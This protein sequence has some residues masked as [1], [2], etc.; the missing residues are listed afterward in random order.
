MNSTSAVQLHYSGDPL[1]SV[2]FWHRFPGT[3]QPSTM[4]TDLNSNPELLHINEE[5]NQTQENGNIDHTRLD[6]AVLENMVSPKHVSIKVPRFLEFA[7]DIW[8]QQ[9]DATFALHKVND[10]ATR[11]YQ[12]IASLEPNII[13]RVT[14]YISDPTP[15]RQYQGLIA[16][17]QNAFA[18]SDGERFE[19]I[20]NA[21]LGDQKASQLYYTMRRLWLDANPDDSKTLRHLFLRKLPRHIAVTLKSVQY[22]D[23]SHFLNAT[24]AMVDQ[25]RQEQHIAVREVVEGSEEL[26]ISARTMQKNSKKN[27]QNEKK[28]WITFNE[29]GICDYHQNFGTKAY[30]C[31]PGC[32]FDTS[33]RN[34]VNAIHSHNNEAIIKLPS[35]WH[36]RKAVLLKQKINDKNIVVDTGSSYSLLP[37]RSD[38]LKRKPNYDLFKGAQGAPIPV[39]GQRTL[40]VDIGTGRTFKHNFFVAGVQE[41]LLGLDF[42]LEHRLVVDPVHSELFDVDTFHSAKTNATYVDSLNAINFVQGKFHHLWQEFPALTDTSAEKMATRP[43]HGTEHDIILKPD[44]R[45]TNAK[46]RRLFGPKLEAAQNEINTM[47]RLGIIRRSCSDWASPLHVVPKGEGSFR[48]CGDFRHLNA[49]TIPD[50]YPVPHLQDFCRDLKGKRVFSK[51]DLTR[52]FHQIPLSK[53]AIPKTAITT[54]F[55]LFEFIRMPFGLCNAAQT[56]QRCMDNILKNMP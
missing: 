11:Y 54:P 35:T 12:I 4:T 9:C 44:S 7:V 45:P 46:P 51:I 17:L 34:T 6:L 40:T 21:T 33:K 1:V 30:K 24:D 43:S 5:D 15:G 10:E 27:G 18:K 53:E 49:C 19:D 36:Q 29:D 39:Y 42:L 20:M 56:F 25:H 28:K 38:E 31:R 23:L 47:L 8:K 48:P 3:T 50:K 14:A 16:A 26:Q 41:P 32:K 22:Q 13:Q 55:G 2:D 52:A 37:P